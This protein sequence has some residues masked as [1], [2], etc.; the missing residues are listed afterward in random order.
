MAWYNLRNLNFAGLIKLILP[1]ITISLIGGALGILFFN[2]PG[3][4]KGKDTLQAWHSVIQYEKIYD[5]NIITTTRHADFETIAGLKKY[6]GDVMHQIQMLSENYKNVKEEK[7]IDKRLFAIINC[8][9]D[10]YNQILAITDLYLDS[11]IKLVENSISYMETDSVKIMEAVTK[12]NEIINE[13]LGQRL[14]LINRDSST[15]NNILQQLNASY[16]T[17]LYRYRFIS[18]LPGEYKSTLKKLYGDWE[19]LLYN[20]RFTFEKNNS[21]TLTFEDGYT[22][23]GYW[24]FNKDYSFILTKEEKDSTFSFKVLNVTDRSIRLAINDSM[25]VIGYRK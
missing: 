4:I 23:K 17:L 9:V 11:V 5:D 8:K 6:K 3:K 12:S 21:G 7:N 20:G 1:G 15:I 19:F 24:S 13:Y 10:T 25:H 18:R 16:I 2:N 22:R 14:H